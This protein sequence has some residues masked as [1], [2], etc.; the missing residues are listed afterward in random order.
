MYHTRECMCCEY[1][2]LSEGYNY[3]GLKFLVVAEYNSVQR[4][5]SQP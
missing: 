4:I 1:D 3:K 5:T 2:D